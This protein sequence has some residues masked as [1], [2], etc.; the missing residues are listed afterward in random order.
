MRKTQVLLAALTIMATANI[1]AAD[2]GFEVGAFGGVHFF[3]DDSELGLLDRSDSESFEDGYAF[4]VRFGYDFPKYF[5]AEGELAIVGTRGDV[6]DTSATVFEWRANGLAYLTPGKY[7]LFALFGAGAMTLSSEH[8]D[9]ITNDTDFVVH[10]GIG[11]KAQMAHNWGIRADARWLFPPSSNS[12]FV[13]SEVELFLG[14]Y[15]TFGA[16][17][18]K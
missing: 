10:G 9:V 13:A 5:G 15:K 6:S 12:K 3:S 7:R 4:G 18:K 11:M 8:S 16:A 17:S 14:L 1:A 2:E